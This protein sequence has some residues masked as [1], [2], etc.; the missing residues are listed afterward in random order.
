MLGEVGAYLVIRDLSGFIILAQDFHGSCYTVCVKFLCIATDPIPNHCLCE[1]KLD[2]S[3]CYRHPRTVQFGIYISVYTR[4]LMFLP[5][6]I[7]IVAGVALQ[8]RKS[9]VEGRGVR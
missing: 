9:V 7:G 6:A 5:R 4:I 8:D 2:L 1:H 3:V